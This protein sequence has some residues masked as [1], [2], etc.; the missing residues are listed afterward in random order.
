[1]P[2][3]DEV[4]GDGL[5]WENADESLSRVGEDS[6]LPFAIDIGRG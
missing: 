3:N 5:L 1:M 2:G 4:L 6:A